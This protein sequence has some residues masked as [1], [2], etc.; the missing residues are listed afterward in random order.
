MHFGIQM[1]LQNY[2]RANSG[3]TDGQDY[4]EEIRLGLLA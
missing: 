3:V 4:D 1:V 2:D